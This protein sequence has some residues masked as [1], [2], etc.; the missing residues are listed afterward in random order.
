VRVGAVSQT[1]PH[2]LTEPH[3]IQLIKDFEKRFSRA[4]ELPC[5]PVRDHQVATDRQTLDSK[6]QNL[7]DGILDD[8]LDLSA[9]VAVDEHFGAFA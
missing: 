5:N 1:E 6:L 9:A 3:E 7:V 4:Q 2:E 8:E